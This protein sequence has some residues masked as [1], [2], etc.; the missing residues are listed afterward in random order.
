MSRS[1][2]ASRSLRIATDMNHS[3]PTAGTSATS[4]SAAMSGAALWALPLVL[5]DGIFNAGMSSARSCAEDYGRRML[6]ARLS[7]PGRRASI[8]AAGTQAVNRAMTF[9]P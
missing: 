1:C 2:T 4:T 6:S 5:T 9:S 7:Y 8:F 3:T